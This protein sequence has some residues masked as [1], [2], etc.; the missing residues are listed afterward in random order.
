MKYYAVTD[1]PNELMH[2]GVKGMKW[3]Q[4]IFGDKPRSAA[5]KRAA[6]KLSA[7][8]KSGIKKTNAN[9]QKASA[10]RATKKEAKKNFKESQFNAKAQARLDEAL[11][12][13]ANKAIRKEQAAV[14]REARQERAAERREDRR[15][16]RYLQKARQGTLKYKNLRDDQIANISERL[17]LENQARR[18]SGN[19]TP[20]MLT[21][22]KRSI[23]EGVVRGVGSA[24]TVGIEETARAR[25]K[26]KA[27][28]KYGEKLAIQE[29]KY[30]RAKDKQRN[31]YAREEANE[32]ADR[33]YYDML[34]ETGRS[35]TRAE[36]RRGNVGRQA[37]R[38][39]VAE[40]NEKKKLAER[41]RKFDD[42]INSAIV[43]GYTTRINNQNM[44]SANAFLDRMTN[45]DWRS[46]VFNSSYGSSVRRKGDDTFT[47]PPSRWERAKS[48]IRS[49]RY[50]KSGTYNQTSDFDEWQ[51]ATE[52]SVPY[53]SRSNWWSHARKT[54]RY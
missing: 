42:D 5:F 51:R 2:Y 31:K 29:A 14:R 4:H 49:A 33:D 52:D 43:R 26:Y 46:Q 44:E 12:A 13:Q 16:Q 1:D 30:Q 36:K 15:M 11:S 18:L 25:A 35:Q 47:E 32:K 9:W 27:Q 24:V 50:N 23:G 40:Y 45:G 53:G 10:N 19:E 38:T 20:H 3:G 8:M 41:E 22:I 37:R 28:K 39:A 21:R 7:S 54:R 34:A 6:T 17:N 48:A